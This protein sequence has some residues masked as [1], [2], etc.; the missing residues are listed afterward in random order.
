ME[1]NVVKENELTEVKETTEEKVEVK[2]KGISYIP[3]V[4]MSAAFGIGLVLFACLMIFKLPKILSILLSAGAGAGYLWICFG[5]REKLEK[6]LLSEM[7]LYLFF[8]VATTFVNVVAFWAI[9]VALK[10]NTK[11]DEHAWVVAEVLAFIIAVLFA[12]FTNKIW[13]FQNSDFSLK[14]TGK[15][16]LQFFGARIISEAIVMLCMWVLINKMAMI[17]LIAKAIT[18]IINIVLNYVASK[19]LIFKK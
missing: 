4:I 9:H 12:F 3:F 14:N 13:V 15:Q 11:L 19:F 17:E 8:G 7:F 10:N 2:K 5:L 6:W 1:E 18:A 16:I